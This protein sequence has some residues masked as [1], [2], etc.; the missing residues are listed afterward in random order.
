[1]AQFPLDQAFGRASLHRMRAA[2]ATCANDLGATPA[3]ADHLVLIAS[4][5]VTNAI[6]YAGGSGRVRMWRHG[7]AL[8]CQVTDEGPGMPEP[9]SKGVARP[10]PVAPSGRGLWVARSLAE[11]IDIE[12]GAKGTVVTVMLRVREAV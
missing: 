9:E 7:S 6:T 2:V 8:Y 1:M 10:D 5:L 11:S 3:Q 12:T 4:E